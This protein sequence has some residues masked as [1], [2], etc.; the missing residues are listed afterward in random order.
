MF[1][2]LWK[3]FVD[4]LFPLSCL[5]CGRE[6]VWLC[7]DCQ[8]QLARYDATRCPNCTAGV[9]P[10]AFCPACSREAQLDALCILYSY[11]DP[12]VEE[13]VQTLKY[14]Y[15]TSLSSVFTDL[16]SLR[17]TELSSFIGKE[18]VIVP[19]PLHSKRERER[20]FNQSAILAKSIASCLNARYDQ[21]ILKRTRYT[22]P[23]AQLNKEGR[24]Q[25][26]RDA[27]ICVDSLAVSNKNVILIDDV[28]TTGTT[29]ES[30]ASALRKCGVRSVRGLAFA[31]G[32][33]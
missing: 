23:Q 1:S 10:H 28:A 13:L 30:A 21:G 33:Q 25:N 12:T 19:I 29:L 8:R 27:F 4:M 15:A 14:R 2:F 9:K 11:D 32:K 22:E 6:D 26:M 17:K 16:F 18:S 3:T 24:K 31:R 7:P 20:G 5:L